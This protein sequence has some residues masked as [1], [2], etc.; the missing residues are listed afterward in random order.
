MHLSTSRTIRRPFLDVIPCDYVGMVC[1][2]T[3][4]NRERRLQIAT[5]NFSGL[6]ILTETK[7]DRGSVSKV[8]A[9][10]QSW[11]EDSSVHVDGYK[12][13]RT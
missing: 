11:E 6:C 1:A 4:S 3:G 8:I 2:M 10:Q 12:W 9:G 7:G 13:P 5:W